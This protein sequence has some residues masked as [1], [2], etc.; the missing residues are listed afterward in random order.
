MDL[1]HEKVDLHR[2]KMDLLREKTGM[3][4]YNN[5]IPSDQGSLMMKIW[6]MNGKM[7]AEKLLKIK[8]GI[9]GAHNFAHNS[10]FCI[11]NGSKCVE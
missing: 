11:F 10:Y 3:Y 4:R 2:E 7:I 1:H 6:K 8:E 5:D 9:S